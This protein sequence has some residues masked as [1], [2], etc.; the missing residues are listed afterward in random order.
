MARRTMKRYLIATAILMASG[1]CFWL[2]DQ[3]GNAQA[4]T[5]YPGIGAKSPSLPWLESKSGA[6][7]F[8]TPAAV[9][10]QLNPQ[11]DDGPDP[12]EKYFVRPELGPW[13]VLITS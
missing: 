8:P 2:S 11:P 9:P 7:Y 4:P 10:K 6:G 13:M 5:A 1:A 3:P 12:N